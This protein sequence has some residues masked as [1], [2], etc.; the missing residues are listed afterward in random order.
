MATNTGTIT[1]FLNVFTGPY[2]PPQKATAI[3]ALFCANGTDT[4]GNP[5][6]SVGITQHGPNFTGKQPASGPI[7]P[8]TI[9]ALFKALFASFPNISVVPASLQPPY[10]QPPNYPPFLSSVNPYAPPTV[11][12]QTTVSTGPYVFQWGPPGAPP[13]PPLSNIP[14]TPS[15]SGSIPACF[16]FTFNGASEIMQLAIYMDRYRF[17]TIFQPGGTSVLAALGHATRETLELVEKPQK[18]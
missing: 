3:V 9:D 6:P 17:V 14:P 10:H 18:R 7:L 12:L 15:L 8:N 13:S 16:V 11:A 1:T 5:I 2:T 4:W